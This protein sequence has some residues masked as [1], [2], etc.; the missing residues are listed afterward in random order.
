M[1]L[2][3]FSTD[4]ALS[5]ADFC[6]VSVHAARASLLVAIVVLIL[7]AASCVLSN[8]HILSSPDNHCIAKDRSCPFSLP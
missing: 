7:A 3:P 8:R 2:S 1:P 5:L 4:R 6:S